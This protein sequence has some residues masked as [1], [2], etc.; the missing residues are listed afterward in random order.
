MLETPPAGSTPQLLADLRRQISELVSIEARLFRAELSEASAHI[1]SAAGLT[2][3]GILLA[4][5]GAFAL[6]AAAV[7]FLMRLNIAPD[8]ACVVVAVIAIAG[9]GVLLLAVRRVLSTKIAAP[10]SLNQLWTLRLK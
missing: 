5:G 1:G 7:L 8:I 10:R 3:L 6:L 2:A 9:G 4:T